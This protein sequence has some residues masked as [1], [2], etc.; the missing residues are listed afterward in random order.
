VTKQYDYEVID[1]LSNFC[2]YSSADFTTKF[3]TY[4][5]FSAIL[6]PDKDTVKYYGQSEDKAGKDQ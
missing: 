5:F 6:H 3:N 1:S 4:A 2:K